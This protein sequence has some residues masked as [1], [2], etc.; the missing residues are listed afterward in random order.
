MHA[1]VYMLLF[2]GCVFG[3]PFYLFAAFHSAWQQNME[4]L[5]LH[6]LSSVA[7]AIIL[8]LLIMYVWPTVV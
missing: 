5:W 7:W 3:I 8:T 2:M 1:A 6:L 4:D